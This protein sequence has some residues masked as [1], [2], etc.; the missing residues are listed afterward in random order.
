MEDNLEL[1]VS[2]IGETADCKG[3]NGKFDTT[4]YFSLSIR[5]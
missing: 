2:F 1:I 3:S 5:G 4:S